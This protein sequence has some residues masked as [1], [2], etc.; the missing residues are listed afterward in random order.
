[1]IKK[2]KQYFPWLDSF[3]GQVLCV[4]A[5]GVIILQISNFAVVCGIQWLYTVQ[6]ETI[7][8]DHLVTY[9]KL[10]N[11]IP[12]Q[13]RQKIIEQLNQQD[14]SGLGNEFVRLLDT[15]P[16]WN[17]ENNSVQRQRQ[18]FSEQFQAAGMRTP[19][20]HIKRITDSGELFRVHFSG[21]EAAIQLTDGSWISI[22]MPQNAD[23][24][25]LVWPQRIFLFVFAL[26]L[27]AITGYLLKRITQPLEKL[28]QALTVFGHFPENAQALEERGGLEIQSLTHAFNLMREH[29][30]WNLQERNRMISAMAHN[31]RTPLTKLQLRI[32]R[33]EPETLRQKLSETISSLAQT[34]SQGLEF[35]RSLST[36]E[37]FSRL[38]LI[39][40]LTSVA[41]DFSDV[42]HNVQFHFN[43]QNSDQP[44]IINARVLCLRRCID[45]LIT[46]ACKYGQK[47]EIFL[48][49]SANEVIVSVN[50]EG[51]GIPEELLGKVLEPY[52]RLDSSR[53]SSTGGLG[54]GLTIAKNMALL[55]NA[56]LS[57]SNRKTGG[58]S[59]RL[60]FQTEKKAL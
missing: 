4:L 31:I 17:T 51:P 3:F 53:N 34:V 24:R 15:E 25:L 39:S 12:S 2:L 7:R 44:I 58:L 52:F 23:D 49:Q 55:N 14:Q 16:D 18:K 47:A 59:A 38:D 56:T 5:A 1:M 46:N 6:A 19:Q 29:I 30:Q 21:I 28:S 50:D 48:E 36:N 41:E 9:W 42:G 32:E 60:R 43:D 45:N 27:L 33:V 10:L 13:E 35:A 8:A 54:L 57:L 20:I 26:I 40:F 11:T 22:E 37:P